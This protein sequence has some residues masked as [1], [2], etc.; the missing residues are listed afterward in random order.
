VAFSFATFIYIRRQV[1]GDRKGPL[2]QTPWKD[3][4]TRLRAAEVRSLTAFESKSLVN[5]KGYLLVDVR[6]AEEFAKRHPRG[7]VN[8][9]LFVKAEVRRLGRFLETAELREKVR[10]RQRMHSA[11]GLPTLPLAP[12]NSSTRNRPCSSTTA[13]RDGA[14]QRLGG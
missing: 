1:L 6:P 4:E 11:C 9:P 14:T 2:M 8:V 10:D 13:Q 5:N 7:A 3:M 12:S